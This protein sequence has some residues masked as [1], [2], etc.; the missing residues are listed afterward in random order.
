MK[1]AIVCALILGQFAA[2]GREPAAVKKYRRPVC[3][4]PTT[5]SVSENRGLFAYRF[6]APV[7]EII[8]ENGSTL[9]GVL[10]RTATAPK[11]LQMLNPAAPP[12]YGT[13]RRLLTFDYDDPNRTANPNLRH[14]NPRPDG[15]RL[16]TL[17][18]FW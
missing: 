1:T 9:E 14:M 2:Q 12:E 3:S 16:L 15:V 4:T 11:P 17:R 13:A 7:G 10:V 6:P 18:S 5:A 8:T